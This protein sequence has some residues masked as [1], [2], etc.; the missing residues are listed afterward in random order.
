VAAVA[1]SLS[2]GHYLGAALNW[3]LPCLALASPRLTAAAAA[4]TSKILVRGQAWVNFQS[5]WTFQEDE[6]VQL[7]GKGIEDIVSAA[8]SHAVRT[9]TGKPDAAESVLTGRKLVGLHLGLCFGV[10]WRAPFTVSGR[11]RHF[12][13]SNNSFAFLPC[14]AV[15][16]HPNKTHNAHRCSLCQSSI[17]GDAPRSFR[18]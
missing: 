16:L 4:R 14:I 11:S 18:P 1:P 5:H 12:L 6:K 7:R 8:T 9:G 13:P 15:P 17:S 2:L 10:L 3:I